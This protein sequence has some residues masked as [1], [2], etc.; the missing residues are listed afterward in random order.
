MKKA[1]TFVYTVGDHIMDEGIK[2]EGLFRISG[3][4][5]YYKLMPGVLA[6]G[7]RYDY[8]ELS[9]H[10]NASIFKAYIRE[11]MNG[12]ISV[13]TDPSIIEYIVPLIIFSITNENRK[14]LIYL[15][16]IFRKV[17][18]Y[19][20]DNKM[21]NAVN[22]LFKQGKQDLEDAHNFS[23]AILGN[24]PKGKKDNQAYLAL[25]KIF[26]IKYGL[27]KDLVSVN[28][29]LRSLL[30]ESVRIFEKNSSDRRRGHD[31][32]QDNNKQANNK[33]EILT[34]NTILIHFYEALDNS[35][36]VNNSDTSHIYES[37]KYLT[38]DFFSNRKILR[39]KIIDLN[40]FLLEFLI[41]E[42]INQYEIYIYNEYLSYES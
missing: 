37:E 20:K 30:K 18:Q 19:S 41:E 6:A 33:P 1:N 12:I 13:Q 14:M 34:Q 29:S 3:K 39:T 40:I 15:Q 28:E 36:R 31:N 35:L 7:K 2:K 26:K 22:L 10:D 21:G 38:S 9:V 16:K 23:P 11:I 8:T 25:I 27:E 5:T 42:Q 24:N 4:Y 32:R 17:N